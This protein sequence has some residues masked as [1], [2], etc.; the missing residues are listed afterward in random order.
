MNISFLAIFFLSILFGSSTAQFPRVSGAPTSNSCYRFK[1]D[2]LTY[3]P[4]LKMDMSYQTLLGYIYFDSL[5]RNISNYKQIDTFLSKI[6]NFD[7]LKY[8]DAL[9]YAMQDY[10]AIL[11]DEFCLAANSVNSNYHSNPLDILGDYYQ[12]AKKISVPI[13]H[14]LLVLT[15]IIQRIK[16]KNITE[17]IDTFCHSPVHPLPKLC[18]TAEVLDTIKGKHFV[19]INCSTLGVPANPC[20][21]FSYSPLWD[22]SG[23]ESIEITHLV[24]DSITGTA[25]TRHPYG[26]NFLKIDSEY[27]CFLGDVMYDNDG[28]FSYYN[29]SPERA[30][31]LHGGFLPISSSGYVK[32]QSNIFGYGTSVPKSVFIDSLRQD[33]YSILHP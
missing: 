1:V 8:F 7:R 28:Q 25:R 20:I 31:G 27:I 2:Q 4:P 10:D 12:K 5:L 19:S 32:D 14:K 21:N 30:P 22:Y 15:G 29:Y 16:I 6:N 33:I 18:I 26:S 9:L 3:S 11:F 13:K 24:Y 17:D 23:E